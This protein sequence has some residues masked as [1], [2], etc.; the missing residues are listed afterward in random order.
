MD[1]ERLLDKPLL[2]HLRTIVATIRA[3]MFV[4]AVLGSALVLVVLVARYFK[5]KPGLAIALGILLV[6]LLAMSTYAWHYITHVYDPPFY[7]IEQLNGSLTVE[8][9]NGHHRY[10]Y[11]RRQ[12][13]VATRDGLR[14]IEFRAH[15]TGQGHPSSTAVESLHP[16]HALLDG[17]RAESDGRVHRWLYPRRALGRGKKLEVGIKQVHEDDVRAQLP[18]F[19]EGGGRYKTEKI[20]VAVRLPLTEHRPDSARGVVWNTHNSAEG[21]QEVDELEVSRHVDPGS[22]TVE[23]TVTI[24]KPALFYS[25]GVE[26][27]WAQQ[28][29]D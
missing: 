3:L 26:W 16:E 4:V 17:K 11:E 5:A 2:R 15:W 25:Y 1:L 6:V 18:Y 27:T 21:S 12:T 9:A 24:D 8:A 7:K 28:P 23:Y 22:G 20:V 10:T 19:R 29:P 14:L 13:V